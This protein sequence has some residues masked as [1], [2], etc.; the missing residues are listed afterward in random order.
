MKRRIAVAA[1]LPV[2]L[3]LAL[4]PLQAQQSA[5]YRLAEF[6]LNEGGHP[7]QGAALTSTSYHVNLDA[8]SDGLAMGQTL[9]SASFRSEAG[10]VGRY[11]PPGEVANLLCSDR[12]TLVWHPERSAG[13]YNVYRDWMSAL[14]GLGFGACFA[15]ALS[16]ATANEPGDPPAG[17]SWFYLVTAENRLGEEGSKGARSNGTARGN[18]EPCP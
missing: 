18:P 12:T 5:S 13:T 11:P 2:A 8:V 15:R 14:S 7:S 6:V 3:A 16:G 9:T 4:P 17:S 1:L 10:F